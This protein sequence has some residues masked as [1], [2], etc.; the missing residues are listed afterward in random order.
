MELPRNKPV[1]LILVLLLVFLVGL[2]IG[3]RLDH[4]GNKPAQDVKLGSYETQET[5]KLTSRLLAC[6]V[7]EALGGFEYNDIE[8]TVNATVNQYISSKA[9]SNI[10]VYFRD[11]NNGGWFG[12]NEK[13]TFSPASL[14]KVPYM[15]SL[16]KL[17]E[18]NPEI[19][20]KVVQYK[21]VYSIAEPNFKPEK[22]LELGASYTIN[23][24]VSR[25]ILY[26]DNE[27]MYLILDS[28]DPKIFNALYEDLGL[29]MLTDYHAVDIAVKSYASFLRILFNASYL[30]VSSSEKALDLLSKTSR[31]MLGRDIPDSVVIANKFGERHYSDTGEDQLHNCGIIYYPKH[32]Y[33]LCVMTRG[34]DY[35]VLSKII[36]ELSKQ[37][38]Q[39]IGIRYGNK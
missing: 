29:G 1:L 15:I 31:K 30:S 26:S 7:P 10:S 18:T 3:W 34:T 27:A 33:L 17:A 39:S 12:V 32:P 21:K 20:S 37:I 16:Y 9:V 19:L 14:L 22:V 13:D 35:D 8:Q 5:G 4:I 25:M 11:L 28:F 2:G 38:Y 36:G 6:D 24:L 23:E